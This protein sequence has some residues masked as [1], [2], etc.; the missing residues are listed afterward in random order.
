MCAVSLHFFQR[1]ISFKTVRNTSLRELIITTKILFRRYRSF[2]Y[3]FPSQGASKVH[4][5]K[6]STFIPSLR[7]EVATPLRA[8][9][10]TP[11]P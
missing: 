6:W 2:L 11:A 4:G 3:T 8:R 10:H 1:G 7:A 9:T 5:R